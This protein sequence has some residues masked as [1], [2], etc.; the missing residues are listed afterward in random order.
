MIKSL[1]LDCAKRSLKN[2]DIKDLL[3]AKSEKNTAFVKAGFI[4]TGIDSLNT[5]MRG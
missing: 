2:G 3:G 4:N 5:A 1:F